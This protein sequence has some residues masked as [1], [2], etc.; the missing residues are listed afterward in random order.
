LAGEVEELAFGEAQRGLELQLRTIDT[1]RTTA[2]SLLTTGAIVGAFLGAGTL[3]EGGLEPAV[4]VALAAFTVLAGVTVAVLLPRSF[5]FLLEPDKLVADYVDETPQPS[6]QVV[7]RDLALHHDESRRRNSETVQRLQ[8]LDQAAAIA[9]G[10]E[11]GAW[12]VAL[13]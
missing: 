6:R 7:L 13:I 8:R 2:G 11:V 1:L 5:Y 10:V 12:L 9:L 4:L 3:K